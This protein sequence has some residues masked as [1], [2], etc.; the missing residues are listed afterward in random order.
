MWPC[1]GHGQEG[2]GQSTTKQYGGGNAYISNKNPSTLN[3]CYHCGKTDHILHFSQTSP[4]IRGQSSIFIRR[5][6]QRIRNRLNYW[7]LWRKVNYTFKFIQHNS[8]RL[9]H[10]KIW[11]GNTDKQDLGFFRRNLNIQC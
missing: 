9:L 4:K 11:L 6:I 5:N 1:P 7:Y 8:L 3:D 10:S 2:C